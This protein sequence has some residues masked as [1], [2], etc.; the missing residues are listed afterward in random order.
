MT[1]KSL[2]E[3]SRGVFVIA[4]VIN[5]FSDEVVKNRVSDEMS[6]NP[7][8]K[9]WHTKELERLLALSRCEHYGFAL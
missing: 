6:Q 8:L 2:Y 9:E 7:A 5:R 4:A 3:R 1:E